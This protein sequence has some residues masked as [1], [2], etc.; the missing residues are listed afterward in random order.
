MEGGGSFCHGKEKA[1]RDLIVV[2]QHLKGSYKDDGGS[3]L[4][5]HHGEDSGQWVQSYTGRVFV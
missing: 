4:Q 2:F 1:W 5:E 3:L